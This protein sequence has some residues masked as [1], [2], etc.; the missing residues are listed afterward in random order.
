MSQ[1]AAEWLLI[2]L[3]TAAAI[4]WAALPLSVLA[5]DSKVIPVTS[6][7]DDAWIEDGPP[8]YNTAAV[9]KLQEEFGI[10]AYRVPLDLP[11]GATITAAYLQLT[12]AANSTQC[13]SPGTYEPG[14]TQWAGITIEDIDDAENYSTGPLITQRDYIAPSIGITIPAMS[15]GMTWTSPNIAS[16]LQAVLDR[17]GWQSGNYVAASIGVCNN[18]GE[19]VEFH[20]YDGNPAL[21]PRLIV[22]YSDPTAIGYSVQL[23]SGHIA[24]INRSITAGDTLI[25]QILMAIAGLLTFSLL[26]RI[27]SI[28]RK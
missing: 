24:T 7:A 15:A 25:I 27:S 8:N 2:T 20:A 3:L 13:Y 4:I 26:L 1:T 22:E 18:S 9:V 28:I 17:P 23:P 14:S 11:A 10:L 19:L 16:Q 21:A 5:A 6:S 12:V